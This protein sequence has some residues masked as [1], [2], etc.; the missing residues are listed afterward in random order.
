MANMD[1]TGVL[2]WAVGKILDGVVNYA[3]EASKYMDHCNDLEQLLH[4]IGPLVSEAAPNAGSSSMPPGS[5][6]AAVGEWLQNFQSLLQQADQTLHEAVEAHRASPGFFRRAKYSKKVRKITDRLRK[7]MQEELGLAILVCVR[8]P[9]S[10]VPDLEPQTV[11]H[12]LT[13]RLRELSR[14]SKQD[15]RCRVTLQIADTHTA[16]FYIPG[17]D[18]EQRSDGAISP[19]PGMGTSALSEEMVNDLA[20]QHRGQVV[21]GGFEVKNETKLRITIRVE[22]VEDWFFYLLFVDHE[23][24]ARLP[25]LF[26]PK[27]DLGDN[28]NSVNRSIK[29]VFPSCDEYDEDPETVKLKRSANAS[30]DACA[31]VSL[32]LL[33]VSSRLKLP[34]DRLELQ[35]LI[36]IKDIHNHLETPDLDIIVKHWKFDINPLLPN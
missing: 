9:D 19:A 25:E 23:S 34:E 3:K 24:P 21:G 31:Q 4:S 33:I 32:F 26:F 11:E 7:M 10:V 15:E 6:T 35:R 5:S 17:C 8:K 22:F 28:C 12:P 2:P 30:A 16:V 29:R 27:N 1:P 14:K 13:C 36:T 18:K 20:N